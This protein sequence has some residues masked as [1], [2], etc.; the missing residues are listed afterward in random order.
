MTLAGNVALVTGAGRGIGREVCLRLAHDGA[1]IVAVDINADPVEET[2]T[3][4]REVGRQAVALTADLADTRV[5]EGLADRVVEQFGRL[6]ILVNNAAVGDPRSMWTIEEAHFDRVF[7]VNVK[8]MFFCLRGAA[9]HM[10]EAGGGK[11]VNLASSAGK[12]GSPNHLHYASTKAAVINIT[13]SASLEL[14]KHGINV[15]CV[16][17][18]IVET[19]LWDK[20]AN[21]YAELA[22]T[23]VEEITRDRIA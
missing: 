23:S 17:P 15:N 14:A 18:G 8:G 12:L 16:C 1:D 13:R 10:R 4:V 7:A 22:G 9:R 5:A 21:V 2:A 3:L 6:D 11:I 20:A 19:T